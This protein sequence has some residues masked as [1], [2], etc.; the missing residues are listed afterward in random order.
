MKTLLILTALFLVSGHLLHAVPERSTQ[1]LPEAHTPF[2]LVFKS[3][4]GDPHKDK[5]EQ[6]S[7]QIDTVDLKQPSSF[8][9]LGEQ[10][11]NTQLKLSKFVY[12]TRLNPKSKESEDVSELTLVNVANGKTAV[13]ILNQLSDAS[14][15]IGPNAVSGQ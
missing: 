10:I 7:F 1:P 11:P 12:K 2:R 9:Q 6:F 15:A 13:L 4:D 8:L 5:V 3:Y 14:A